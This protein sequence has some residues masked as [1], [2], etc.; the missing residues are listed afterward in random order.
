MVKQTREVSMDWLDKI[1][2]R[3]TED[4]YLELLPVNSE[5]TKSVKDVAPA[6]KEIA[7]IRIANGFQG[8]L[9]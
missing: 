1:P 7:E 4:G 8:V 9:S 5:P 6:L 2:S 3:I